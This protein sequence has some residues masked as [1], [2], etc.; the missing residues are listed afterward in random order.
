MPSC[1]HCGS[2]FR[3]IRYGSS[4]AGTRKWRCHDCRRVYTLPEEH[5]V[6][7]YPRAL[8][9]RAVRMYADGLNFRRIGRLLG[10]SHQ[11][12]IDWVN[13]YHA[14]L[15]EAHPVPPMPEPGSIET[16]EMDELF[17]RLGKKG[18]SSTSAR[19]YTSARS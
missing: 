11:T 13:A 7:G 5:K 8:K 18:R 6:R 19:S 1:P 10:V 12:V 3:Q 2:S 9:E 4:P 15:E 14:R 16:V 17:A